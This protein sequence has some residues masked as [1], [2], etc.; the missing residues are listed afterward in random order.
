MKTLKNTWGELKELAEQAASETLIK[1]SSRK[2]FQT[3]DHGETW[4]EVSPESIHF[5]E[6]H[7]FLRGMGEA[8]RQQPTTLT[9]DE[10]LL[11]ALGKKIYFDLRRSNEL[12]VEAIEEMVRRGDSPVQIQALVIGQFPHLW[13][14]SQQIKA[15]AWYLKQGGVED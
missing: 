13:V 15:V 2:I 6:D 4:F 3:N 9:P 8:M 14:E 12:A 1:L 11:I 5:N 7:Y 10:K